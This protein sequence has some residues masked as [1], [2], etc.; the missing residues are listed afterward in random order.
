MFDQDSQV[1]PDPY[2]GPIDLT[3]GSVTVGTP[4]AIFQTGRSIDP[5]VSGTLTLDES[6]TGIAASQT[7]WVRLY[8]AEIDGTVV[9]GNRT[10][11]VSLEGDLVLEDYDPISDVGSF[12]GVA[13]TFVVTV[14]DDGTPDIDISLDGTGPLVSAVEIIDV[15][16]ETYDF[17]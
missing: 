10:F 1:D 13:K 2:D 8:F 16:L 14:D 4:L 7:Y 12:A 17:E 11:D 6:W 3:N 5:Q 15:V 9:V